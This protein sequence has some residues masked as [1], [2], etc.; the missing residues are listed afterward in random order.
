MSTFGE[1]KRV[2]IMQPY[3]FP[4]MGYFQLIDAVDEFWIFDCVQYIS[5][6]WMNRN[7]ILLNGE[8][9]RFT[10][11]VED[12]PRSQRISEKRYSP[13]AL[14]DCSQLVRSLRLS[15]SLSRDSA[16]GMVEKLIHYLVDRRISRSFSDVTARTLMD[17]CEILGITTPLKFS[18]EL[19]VP[20]S[21]R[22]QQRVLEICRRVG[23]DH[24]LNLPS[25]IDLYDSKIFLEMG[26]RIS[27]LQPVFHWYPQV[28]VRSFV[29]MLSVLDVVANISEK[30]LR[31][32]V[33]GYNL[34]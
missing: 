21:Y 30:H 7:R 16:V 2:A 15:G 28:R 5:R 26:V 9:K 3:L 29:P 18:S 6:G 12:G 34:N 11:S 33:K 25:G 22:G 4:Y 24:Y 8:E 32:Y 19:S 1:G 31:S 13:K 27:F 20:D 17:G 14:D 23:A 10:V